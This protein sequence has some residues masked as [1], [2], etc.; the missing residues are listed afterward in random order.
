[1]RSQFVSSFRLPIAVGALVVALTLGSN[2]A[3]AVGAPAGTSIDNTAQV[4]YSIGATSATASSNTVSVTVAEILDVVVTLQTPS[5][6]VTGGATQQELVYRVTNTGN[7]PEAFS[8][9][10][11]SVLGGDDFDPT[12]ATPPIYFDT[13]ASGDLSPGD[14]PYV[15]GTNDPNLNADAFVTVLVVNNIPASVV[16]GNRGL[17]RLTAA[18]RTGIG[19][20]GTNFAGQ[21][22]SGTD[23]VVGTTGADGEA[24]GQYLVSGITV[25]AVKSQTVVDQF[26]GA[27]PV[28]GARINYSIAVSATGSGTAT[29]AVFTDNVPANT[30]YVPGTLRLN[31]A[32]LT[33]GADV[34]A[35]DFAATPTARVRVTLGNLTQA[36]GSQT[37]DFAVTIN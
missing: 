18:A 16:D 1:M 32:A 26:G 37:I 30:T 9:V 35:G 17:S 23:A 31:G 11:T 10:M 27:R 28:P 7:G 15:I 4:T 5:V 19:A 6:N 14:A 29:A 33:D 24:T 22:V 20:P 34:D 8:L 21:G 12:A 3:H 36:S 25:N 13:D 2:N